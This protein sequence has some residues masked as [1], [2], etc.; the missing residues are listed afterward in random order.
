[1]GPLPGSAGGVLGPL[2]RAGGVT[3]PTG[4]APSGGGAGPLPGSAGAVGPVLR[5]GGVTAPTGGLAGS[6]G[7]VAAGPLPGSAGAAGPLPR[8]GG[9]NPPGA[10]RGTPLSGSTALPPPAGPC[11][12]GRRRR[13][14]SP[15]KRV[16]GSPRGLA[17]F[18]GATER[19]KVLES[20]TD[21]RP[22]VVSLFSSGLRVFPGSK[23]FQA[24]GR[25]SCCEAGRLTSGS[26]GAAAGS[27]LWKD[28]I[29]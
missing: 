9:S 20:G 22:S 16:S 26:R 4:G 17:L 18:S 11:S 5:A 13:R 29:A 8:A 7:S 2:L 24:G 23:A 10:G 21:A 6:T 27:R 1:M 25:L 12:T 28:G 3:P 14:A 19:N 15:G